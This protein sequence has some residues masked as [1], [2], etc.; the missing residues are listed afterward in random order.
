MAGQ[1]Y[2]LCGR[3]TWARTAA[4]VALQLLLVNLHS[5]YLLGLALT[6][7]FF[8]DRVLRLAWW[9][10]RRVAPPSLEVRRQATML[11]TAMAAKAAVAFVNP[12]GWRIAALPFET[13][14]FLHGHRLWEAQ[15]SSGAWATIGEVI[16][17]LSPLANT[18]LWSVAWFK[19]LLVLLAAGAV[20][21]AWRRRWDW[22]IV[23]VLLAGVGVSMRRNMAF[24]ALLGAPLALAA[25]TGVVGRWG[26]AWLTAGGAAAV[27]LVSAGLCVSVAT[28][29]FYF[30]QRLPWRLGVG[31]SP[32]VLPLGASEWLTRNQPQGRLWTDFDASS[33]LHYFTAPKP[34]VPILTNTWAVPPAV[35]ESVLGWLTG[36]LDFDWA[37]KRF[38]LESAAFAVDRTT[39]LQGTGYRPLLEVVRDDPAWRLVCID[40]R[41]VVYVR[42]D[43]PNAELAA[44]AAITPGNFAVREYI[45][46]LR[47]AGPVPAHALYQGG[48]TL[49]LLGWNAHAAELFAAATG[50]RENY[51][52]A[53]RMLGA[54]HARMG[55]ERL[56]AGDRPGAV[57]QWQLAQEALERSLHIRPD[58]APAATD[59]RAVRQSLGRS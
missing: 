33:N 6:G 28:Q 54:S 45:E 56:R 20:C 43:G 4:M 14:A 21:A 57:R 52:E 49:F 26:R 42:D 47:R 59:L 55:D 58:Y 40:G 1:L 32:T 39:A 13:L 18:G 50:D 53:W 17:P 27:A 22:L 35:M 38:G 37:R 19:A 30:A 12:W 51:H 48:T 29:D 25:V 34:P 31:L 23:I 46:R 15:P 2:L 10:V 5:Y 3:A 36:T 41:F 16:S 24:C 44:R 7:A 9:R 8:A 11:G